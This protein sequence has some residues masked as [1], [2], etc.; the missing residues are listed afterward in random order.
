MH[1]LSI[2]LK[3]IIEETIGKLK[4]VSQDEWN[5]RSAPG[6]WT[7]KEILG[8]LIDSAANNHQRFVKVQFEE[9]PTIIYNPDNWN[10][11]QKYNDADVSTLIDLFITYNNHLAYIIANTPGGNFS[12]LCNI[13]K[14]KP[15]TLEWLITDYIR[16]LKHH[17]EQITHITEVE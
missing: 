1:N 17:L 10:A 3:T 13:G 11:V 12:K 8:H 15:V 2:Q 4:A 14:E 9:T 7:K 6:K 16:H 5:H